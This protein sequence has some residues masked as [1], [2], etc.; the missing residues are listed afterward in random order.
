MK[1]SLNYEVI[2]AKVL[3]AK[4][5][6]YL[7]FSDESGTFFAW[8]RYVYPV[9]EFRAIMNYRGSSKMEQIKLD[10]STHKLPFSMAVSVSRNAAFIRDDSGTAEISNLMLELSIGSV[11]RSPLKIWIN[12]NGHMPKGNVTELNDDESAVIP[13]LMFGYLMDALRKEKETNGQ[14]SNATTQ[15]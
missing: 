10:E 8:E 1:Q 11:N 5:G 6:N 2:R 4:K 15:R 9:R 7:L 3:E 13:A 14:N 12:I